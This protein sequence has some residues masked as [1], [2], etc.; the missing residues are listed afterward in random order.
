MLAI[1]AARFGSRSVTAMAMN[2]LFSEVICV[3]SA[4]LA[5]ATLGYFAL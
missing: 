2:P 3:F 1:A 5:R 4:S